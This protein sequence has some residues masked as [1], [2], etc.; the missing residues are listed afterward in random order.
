MPQNLPLNVNREI[1][2][3]GEK[4][5]DTPLAGGHFGLS[6]KRLRT[7]D[8]LEHYFC[9]EIVNVMTPLSFQV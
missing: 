4:E 3:G 9:L 5:E 2:C 8:Y 6:R 1:P 7:S